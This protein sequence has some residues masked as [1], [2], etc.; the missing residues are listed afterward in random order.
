MSEFKVIY[1]KTFAN[2]NNMLLAEKIILSGLEK[3]KEQ[4]N[5]DRFILPADKDIRFFKDVFDNVSKCFI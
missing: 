3:Y 5:H 1:S 4:M 2:E